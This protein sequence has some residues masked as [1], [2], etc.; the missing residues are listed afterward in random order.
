MT[1]A[2]YATLNRLAC[3]VLG[4]WRPTSLAKVQFVPGLIT[5][6]HS[7]DGAR[8]RLTGR[9]IVSHS[10]ACFPSALPPASR[11]RN[12]S[13]LRVRPNHGGEGSRR[14]QSLVTWRWIV[15]WRADSRPPQAVPKPVERF[16][17]EETHRESCE[18]PVGVPWSQD[19]NLRANWNEPNEGKQNE[20]KATPVCR[21]RDRCDNSGEGRQG[22][23]NR[24]GHFGQKH[25][26][27]H[28]VIPWA[29]GG[30]IKAS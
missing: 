30:V 16:G 8:L 18:H 4:C 10:R 25:R 3:S 9:R 1:V 7:Q 13:F 23:D 5:H 29:E 28:P 21:I 19:S 12:L 2:R 26:E 27:D 15:R 20:E 6:R 24:A 17:R 11:V 22:D 14:P